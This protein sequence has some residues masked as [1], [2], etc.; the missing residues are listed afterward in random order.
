MINDVSRFTTTAKRKEV[1]KQ[2]D[3]WAEHRDNG[4][5]SQSNWT[6]HKEPELAEETSSGEFAYAENRECRNDAEY[7]QQR[8]DKADSAGD[9]SHLFPQKRHV[10]CNG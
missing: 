8:Q 7:G 4:Q 5:H 10:D 2:K 3:G 1:G 9:P 6:N